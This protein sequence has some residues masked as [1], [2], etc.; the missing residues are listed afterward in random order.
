MNNDRFAL[1]QLTSQAFQPF[2]QNEMAQAA[3]A[4]GL[5]G[6]D[7]FVAVLAHG[8]KPEFFSAEKYHAMY[9]YTN[10]AQQR[11]I[12]AQRVERGILQPHG[13]GTFEIT[14]TATTGLLAS[15]AAVRQA[16]TQLQPLAAT[17]LRYLADLL[18]E[19]VMTTLQAPHPGDKSHLTVS[20]SVAPDVGAAAVV[21]IEQFLTDLSWFRDSAHIAAWQ[22]LGVTGIVWETLTVIWRGEANS[23]ESIANRIGT[24]RGYTADDYSR[25]LADLV[26]RGWLW[27]RGT[28]HTL[29]PKGRQVREEA[30]ARTDEFFYVGW[31]A[32]TLTQSAE[33]QDGLER[34]RDNLDSMATNQ[35]T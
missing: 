30:E 5:E 20:R 33:L 10:I 21:L 9:P 22:P 29:S 34:L 2:Y 3:T 17:E 7:W 25:A 35:T 26:D 24:S 16:L 19:I 4:A 11:H 32:L 6:P 23:A 12:V 15:F 18:A 1:I 31:D 28:G 27:E 8:L 14:E 13:A